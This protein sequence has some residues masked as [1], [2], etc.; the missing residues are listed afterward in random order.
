MPKYHVEVY[1]LYAQV[2]E[3]EADSEDAAI[4]AYMDGEGTALDDALDY[5]E[6]AD[7]YSRDGLPDSIRSVEEA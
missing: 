1:E 4:E 5:I 6:T 7:K 2:Y 3:V